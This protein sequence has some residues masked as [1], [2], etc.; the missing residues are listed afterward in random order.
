MNRFFYF[1]LTLA[2]LLSPL[3][4][5][6]QVPNDPLYGD[7]WYL[8]RIQA[9]SAWEYNTGSS[10]I[11][12]AVLD[13]GIDVVHEDLFDN[14][15]LNEEEIY[16]NN[17]DND[18]NGY[19]DDYYGY[20]F[21]LG[22]GS[23]L[24]VIFSDDL[25]PLSVQHGSIV[26]GIIAAVGNNE[27][28]I[29]GVSW[30]S[31]I[32]ALRVLSENGDGYAT[33]V[34]EGIYYAVNNGARIINLSFSGDNTTQVLNDAIRYAYDNGVIVIVAAGNEARNIN[35][36]P[37]YPACLNNLNNN[38]VIGVAS[39]DKQDQRADFSNYGSNCV[40]ISAPGVDMT[41]IAYYD[42]ENGYDKKYDGGWQGTSFSAPVVSGSIALLL[43]EF[44]WLT[45]DQVQEILKNSADVIF[46]PRAEHMGAGRLNIRSAFDLV[47]ANPQLYGFPSGI[48]EQE[49]EIDDEIII[50]TPPPAETVEEI[51]VPEFLEFIRTEDSS[52]VYLLTENG[53]KVV[54]NET[55]FNTYN[56]INQVLRFISPAEMATHKF[57]GLVLPQPE[58]VLVKIQSDPKVY[59]LEPNPENYYAPRLRAIPDEET[60]QA[61]FGDK[62]ADYIIDIDPTMFGS[63]SQ[64]EPISST[65]ILP[66]NNL[67]TRFKLAE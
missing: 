4:A 44:P 1:S 23:P 5:L 18:G 47:Y 63:F 8:R 45:P 33:D 55:T 66:L 14:L 21:V 6:A 15:W 27:I 32:M 3:T 22:E 11:V 50:E 65:T 20:D 40:D 62:W 26:A 17:E 16:G 37:A 60:A 51:E 10:E 9:N 2:F 48:T 67:V 53:R 39:S 12:I 52:T 19:I 42:P 13:S 61:Q 36:T 28:G 24:P 29:T 58:R 31:R 56:N 34:A 49:P 38:W 7:Q 25:D 54:L 57:A 59:W 30:N 46:G 64:G 41:S 43:S 35:E